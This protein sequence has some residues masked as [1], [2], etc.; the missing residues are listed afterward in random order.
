VVQNWSRAFV[1]VNMPEGGNVTVRED[2]YDRF[3]NYVAQE[4]PNYIAAC[5]ILVEALA[6]DTVAPSSV[7]IGQRP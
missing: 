3:F 5:K 4:P 7:E 6:A 1:W 2:Y